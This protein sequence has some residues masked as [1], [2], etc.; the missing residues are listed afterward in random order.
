MKPWLKVKARGKLLSLN[1]FAGIG[2]GQAVC[3]GFIVSYYAVLLAI[4]LSYIIASFSTT[5]PW[6]GC[7]AFPN[8][9]CVPSVPDLNVTVL[10]ENN[11]TRSSSELYFL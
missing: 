4:T 3:V 1:F 11:D 8:I 7:E 6:A 2:I 10:V 5:L 9:S